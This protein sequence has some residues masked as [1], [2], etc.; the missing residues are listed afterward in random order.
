MQPVLLKLPI[1]CCSSVHMVAVNFGVCGNHQLVQ[2][3]LSVTD[4]G[5]SAAVQFDIQVCMVLAAWAT[6]SNPT[7]THAHTHTHAQSD[8]SCKTQCVELILCVWP[9]SAQ[10]QIRLRPCLLCNV[11]HLIRHREF[12]IVHPLV[13]GHCCLGLR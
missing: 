5:P 2:S 12:S 9:P 11:S 7:Q 3:K 8:A 13:R 10:L 4:A 6:L 1:F